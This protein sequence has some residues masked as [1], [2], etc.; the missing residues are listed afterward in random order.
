MK[1]V[2]INDTIEQLFL[3]DTLWFEVIGPSPFGKDQHKAYIKNYRTN[4]LL[5]DEGLAIYL[6]HPLG[7][8]MEHGKWK[9]Y[10]CSGKLV[11]TKESFEGERQ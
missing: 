6:D 9:Y 1:Q 7:D 3:N 10:D 8:Y 2:K 5:E 4:G 11:E